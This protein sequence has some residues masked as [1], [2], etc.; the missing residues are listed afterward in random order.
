MDEF[1]VILYNIQ[2]VDFTLTSNTSANNQV[3]KCALFGI[4]SMPVTAV[5]RRLI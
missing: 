4:W 5:F 1:F 3:S 2:S